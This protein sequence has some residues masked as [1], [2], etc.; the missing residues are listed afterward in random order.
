MNKRRTAKKKMKE[1]VG[2]LAGHA[3]A[4]FLIEGAKWLIEHF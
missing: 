4:S 1:A 3:L 2:R